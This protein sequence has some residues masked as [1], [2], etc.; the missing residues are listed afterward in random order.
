MNEA[1]PEIKLT[2][3]NCGSN[4][5]DDYYVKNDQKYLEIYLA[6]RQA[7]SHKN[8]SKGSR[9]HS[10]NPTD[11]ITSKDFNTLSYS[12]SKPTMK[13]PSGQVSGLQEN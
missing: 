9:N 5:V 11:K 6:Q 12:I 3:N 1:E 10:S 7:I 4:P 2:Q 13:Y 8:S